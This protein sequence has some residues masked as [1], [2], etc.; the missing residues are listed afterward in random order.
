MWRIEEWNRAEITKMLCSFSRQNGYELIS[1][2][3]YF[4]QCVLVQKHYMPF[5]KESKPSNF[6]DSGGERDRM[7]P[8]LLS[9][10]ANS[11][12]KRQ[13]AWTLH[14]WIPRWNGLTNLCLN[15]QVFTMRLP[16]WSACHLFVFFAWI[17]NYKLST[18]QDDK[19]LQTIRR[20]IVGY[21]QLKTC[22][23]CA[24]SISSIHARINARP[25]KLT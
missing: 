20:I 24:L 17:A 3:R 21:K 9:P 8:K 11:R 2:N 10:R 23:L 7:K 6:M 18:Q 19:N 15:P 16:I 13:I 25:N 5:C 4:L 14:N 22:N 1:A 12:L